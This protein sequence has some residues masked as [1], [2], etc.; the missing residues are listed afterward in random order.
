MQKVFTDSSNGLLAAS[1]DGEKEIFFL[2]T[3]TIEVKTSNHVLQQVKD[4]GLGDFIDCPVSGGIPAARQGVLTFMVG[5]SQD[6]FAR[7]KPVLSS[8]GREDNILF[9]GPPGAGLA[10]K[11][12]N[13]YIANVSYVALC[14]GSLGTT[15]PTSPNGALNADTVLYRHEY[16]YSLWPGPEALGE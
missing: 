11:Q 9:C 12:I 1:G 6:L 4:S 3:S 14:E 15:P 16:W 7:A 10:T 13:N 2:E 8:M 5:G